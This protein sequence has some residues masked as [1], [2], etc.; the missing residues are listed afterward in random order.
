MAFSTE[1]LKE[2]IEGSCNFG[3]NFIHHLMKN[4]F[5]WYETCL[6][7]HD[8][9][10]KSLNQIEIDK[11]KALFVMRL[12][13]TQESANPSTN[14]LPKKLTSGFSFLKIEDVKN[15][16]NFGQT[17]GMFSA[18]ISK[19]VEDCHIIY[20]SI[21]YI[22]SII[23]DFS[24]QH[25]LV[26]FLIKR[27]NDLEYSDYL[28]AFIKS[29]RSELLALF[30]W[31]K[32]EKLLEAGSLKLL[33][34]RWEILDEPL[35]I[36][37]PFYVALCAFVSRLLSRNSEVI[38]FSYKRVVRKAVNEIINLHPIWFVFDCTFVEYYL[39]YTERGICTLSIHPI[40]GTKNIEETYKR[41]LMTAFYVNNPNLE[42]Q[43]SNLISEKDKFVKGP[44]LEVT[45]PY[46]TGKSI[47][48][49]INEGT[50]SPLMG[51][52][53]QEE[54]PKERNLYVHQEKAIRKANVGRNFVVATGTGSG[55]TES[56]LLPILNELFMQ[57]ESGKLG[58]GV[59]ALLIY[60]MN[61]LANDQVK[62]LRRLISRY[63]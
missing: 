29:Y 42:N 53:S 8:E 21:P 12:F 63:S 3:E 15:E 54:M 4:H 20:Q 36:N 11:D 55:K 35:D 1:Q 28:R 26:Q 22:E 43:F 18:M 31:L 38:P 48:D 59:R 52:L 45:A 50:L 49:L 40:N 37:F 17:S 46:Q 34:S 51:T 27:K 60:P 2:I 25:E 56:F 41:Y 44:F 39:Q 58:P 57:K 14:Q 19:S 62:R 23:N 24:I 30:D 16:G 6:L 61:A 47:E 7:H 5:I 10:V 33:N 9:I 13:G 32:K